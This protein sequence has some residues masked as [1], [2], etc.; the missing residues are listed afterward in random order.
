M[1]KKKHASHV[2]TDTS[3]FKTYFQNL[4]MEKTLTINTIIERLR[5][6]KFIHRRKKCV[7]MISN[8]NKFLGI[9]SFICRET[10]HNFK[11]QCNYILKKSIKTRKIAQHTQGIACNRV[12]MHELLATQQHIHSM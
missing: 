12:F 8:E 1:Y 11:I 7:A 2:N 10:I 4:T 5:F 9:I 3:E 6:L